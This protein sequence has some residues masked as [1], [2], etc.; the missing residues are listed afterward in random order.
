LELVSLANLHSP[1]EDASFV[2]IV[3]DITTRLDGVNDAVFA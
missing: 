1:F 3:D 2:A